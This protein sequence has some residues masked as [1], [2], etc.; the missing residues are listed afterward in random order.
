MSKDKLETPP[1]KREKLCVF[2]THAEFNDSGCWGDYPDPAKL[3]CH[4]GHFEGRYHEV[5][6][7]VYDMEDFRKIIVQAES[8]PDYNEVKPC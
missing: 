7:P 8:C 4:K 2:C 6:L 1:H 3:E 5:G